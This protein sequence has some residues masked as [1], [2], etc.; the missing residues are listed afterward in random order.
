MKVKRLVWWLLFP[1]TL[2]CYLLGSLWGAICKGWNSGFDDQ[3]W[4]G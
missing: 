1:V 3:K 2:L 4:G